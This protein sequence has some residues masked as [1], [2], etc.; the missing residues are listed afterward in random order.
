MSDLTPNQH[1][2][3]KILMTDTSAKQP[4]IGS[5]IAKRI[6]LKAMMTVIESS[7]MRSIIHTLRV[8]GF[9]IC[10]NSRGYFYAKTQEELSKFIMKFEK[11]IMGEEEALKGLKESFHNV[12]LINIVKT[13]FT[14]TL[15]IRN[16]NGSASW[17]EFRLDENGNPIIPESIQII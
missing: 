17:M 15:A 1:A 5:V 13:V 14:K 6:N 11:R 9:P 12:G 4:I 3:L 16:A 8:E 10:A 7:A 2:T